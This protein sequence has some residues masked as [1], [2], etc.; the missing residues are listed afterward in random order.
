MIPLKGHFFIIYPSVKIKAGGC[1]MEPFVLQH[2]TDPYLRL[3]E[4][5]TLFPHLVVGIST[6]SAENRNYALH[7]GDNPEQVIKNRVNLANKLG[8]PFHNWTCGEQVHSCHIEQVNVTN[9]GKGRE[10]RDSAFVD[11]DGLITDEPETLLTSF[12]A[13][14]VPLYFY[15]PDLDSIGVAHAGWKGTALNIGGKMVEQYRSL[16][17]DSK[18]LM[19]A[20]GPSIGACCYEVD[21]RVMVPLTETFGKAIPTSIAAKTSP[22][23]YRL[24]LKAANAA[25]LRMTGLDQS[26]IAVSNRC[27]NCEDTLFFSYRR[28]GTDAGRMVSFIG[29]QRSRQDV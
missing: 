6:R 8:F 27:T 3:V 17:A 16:G 20:I 10:S 7:V 13:D 14:C 15:S 11:T 2:N 29:K 25:L 19:V 26:Q 28:E 18:Q 1:C 21:E 5:E 22:G 12:Y 24:D 23:H 9:R 4:W